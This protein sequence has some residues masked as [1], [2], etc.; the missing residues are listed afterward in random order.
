M[1]ENENVQLAK[2]RTFLANER[3]RLANQRT[4]L[5]WTRT[6]LACVAGGLAIIRFFTFENYTH[7]I[8]SEIVG[9]ILVFLGIAIFFLSFFE[10]ESNHKKHHIQKAYVGAIWSIRAITFVLIFV[11]IALLFI[12]L[13]LSVFGK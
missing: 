7:Q 13:R 6:G 11:S 5:A 9:F 12:A 8:T 3:N 4:F 10:F 2:E 1:P